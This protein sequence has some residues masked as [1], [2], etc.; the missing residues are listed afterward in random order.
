MVKSKCAFEASC[1]LYGFDTESIYHVLCTY[2]ASQDVSDP[3]FGGDRDLPRILWGIVDKLKM[4][5]LVTQTVEHRDKTAGLYPDR[6]QAVSAWIGLG[7]RV[8][9]V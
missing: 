8:V 1:R 3:S 7:G 2:P 5:A 4:A 9:A 6:G